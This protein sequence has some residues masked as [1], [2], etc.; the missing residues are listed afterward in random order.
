M[1]DEKTKILAIGNNFLQE[2]DFPDLITSN[3][4]FSCGITTVFVDTRLW[5][6][7]HLRKCFQHFRQ[8]CVLLTDR[9]E[10]H[11]S[12]PDGMAL[13]RFKGHTSGCNWWISIRSV[14]N[15]QD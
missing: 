9:I 1:N 5:K 15:A 13:R 11:Q 6:T 12:Q 4:Y 8:S 2:L 7:K 14:N 3:N 10:I